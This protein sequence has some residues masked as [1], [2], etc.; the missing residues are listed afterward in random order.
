[1]AMTV[2][3]LLDVILARFCGECGK[4]LPR[5]GDQCPACE[6]LPEMT[7][8]E[9]EERLRTDPT[10]FAEAESKAMLAAASAEAGR[11]R[12]EGA[13]LMRQTREKFQ[14]ADRAEFIA[15][16]E[17]AAAR[18]GRELAAARATEGQAAQSLKDA[19]S[20]EQ[21]AAALLADAS[22]AHSKAQQ[23]E[24]AA[25]RLRKGVQ[26]EIAAQQRLDAAA[27][28]L[29]RHQA[30]H[31]ACK[32]ACVQ[33]RQHL[34]DT[35]ADAKERETAA[36][37]LA[38]A[39]E[40]TVRAPLSMKTILADIGHLAAQAYAGQLDAED[41]VLVTVAVQALVSSVGIE[42]DI[43]R[44]EE[45]R[46]RARD[47][48]AARKEPQ[49]AKGA[50]G[51]LVAA[52]PAPAGVV[53]PPN[54]TKPAPEFGRPSPWADTFGPGTSVS[55][56]IPGGGQVTKAYEANGWWQAYMRPSGMAG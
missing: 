41:K 43:R 13:D 23:D 37:R 50:D 33:A 15:Q 14:A 2:D 30:A 32:A 16:L 44:D 8:A 35:S 48:A 22:Q 1:M 39:V 19:V 28:V 29:A 6:A 45:Q 40:H 46:V 55:P 34:A 11:L 24:E 31:G 7:R 18:A 38:Y 26:A 10:A 5:R 27:T 9:A 54:T 52:V 36:N 21:E 4:E 53:V 51:M 42:Q 20:A 47:A 25:R 3:D 12:D 56:G 17:I 49:F